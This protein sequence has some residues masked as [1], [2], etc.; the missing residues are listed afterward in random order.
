MPLSEAASTST[1]ELLSRSE[2]PDAS[3]K[4]RGEVVPPR[5]ERRVEQDAGLL[6]RAGQEREP[7]DSED[8]WD[9]ST[10]P[11][12]YSQAT[13]RERRSVPASI[14][15]QGIWGRPVVYS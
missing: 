15:A 14:P 6:M 1:S 7:T 9:S 13:M 3:E 11:P 2:F 4:G 8:L 5:R 10:L 12:D